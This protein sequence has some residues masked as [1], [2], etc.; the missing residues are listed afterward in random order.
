M[1]FSR[2]KWKKEAGLVVLGL[3]ILVGCTSISAQS[4]YLTHQEQAQLFQTV[5]ISWQKKL[6]RHVPLQAHHPWKWTNWL[7][8]LTQRQQASS[9]LY[10]NAALSQKQ[11]LFVRCRPTPCSTQ[12]LLSI[13]KHTGLHTV[14][15]DIDALR[16]ELWYA[17]TSRT[18]LGGLLQKRYRTV[19][20][21]LHNF[22]KAPYFS[23]L[24]RTKQRR[25]SYHW[26]SLLPS[27]AAIFFALLTRK[28]LLSLFLGVLLGSILHQGNVFLGIQGTFQTYLW[29]HAIYKEFSFNIILFTLSL[30]GM[31]NVCTRN[32]GVRGLIDTLSQ[33]AS[34]ARSSRIITAVLGLLIFFDDYANTVMVGNTMRP[35]TDRY[36][37]SR[38][39]LA[40]LIDSTAAPIAAIALLSTWIGHEVG[41]LTSISESLHLSM[42][43]YDLFLASLPFRFYC[44]MMLL[45]VFIGVW[46]N[47]DYGPMYD[48]EIRAYQKGKLWRDGAQLMVDVDMEKLHPPEDI[49]YHW[50]NAL[51]PIATV[52]LSGSIGLLYIGGYFQGSSAYQALQKASYN[53]SRIFLMAA[54]LGSVVAIALSVTQR[55]LSLKEALLAWLA[56]ARAMV[57]AVGILLLAWA[58]GQLTQD[59]GTAHYLI[60]LLKDGFQPELL[61]LFVFLMSAAVSFATGTSWGTMGILLPTIGPL[62]YSMGG[63]PILILSVGA[64]LDGSIFGDH[65]SPLS[66]T[67]LF[68]SAAAAC[69]HVDHVRT[70][71]PYALTVMLVAA[72][73]GYIWV[74]FG[75]SVWFCLPISVLMFTLVFVLIGKK[76]DLPE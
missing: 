36:R 63:L 54:V 3:L 39:K 71:V 61:P 56:G 23:D 65:C 42:G 8:Q 43:G 15:R 37:V 21:S 4:S 26:S 30:I 55:L 44:W 14:K 12:L 11:R 7:A 34:T 24:L 69:D 28:I 58:M 46:M 31:I 66:D 27:L 75:G 57:F 76:I 53:S 2:I 45:F 35:L 19:R 22:S 10:W 62:A 72:T 68:S 64:V 5:Y 29:K 50:R 49:P 70:Q 60:A 16:L 52:F 6:Q 48:A 17:S 18:W 41:M 40:Y 33:R 74:P 59:L 20:A 51:I 38:E 1:V 32:G 73:V 25:A 47:R 13:R 9:F 67:T